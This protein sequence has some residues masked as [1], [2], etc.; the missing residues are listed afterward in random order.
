[1]DACRHL[2]SLS[3]SG[4]KVP[5]FYHIIASEV[6]EVNDEWTAFLQQPDIRRE[7][8]MDHR[9]P[10]GVDKR[11]LLPWNHNAGSST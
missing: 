9:L 7:L 2:S 4:L 3:G 8:V 1:V 6:A 10:G 11:S 5:W